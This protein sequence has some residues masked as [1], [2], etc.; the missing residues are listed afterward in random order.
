MRLE[1]LGHPSREQDQALKT[2]IDVQAKRHQEAIAK[3]AIARELLWAEVRHAEGVAS[4][5][6]KT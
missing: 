6:K 3:A 5:R 2:A 4:R 1:I